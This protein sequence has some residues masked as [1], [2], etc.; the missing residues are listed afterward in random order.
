MADVRCGVVVV[1]RRDETYL[2]IRRAAHV[3][4]PGAWCFVGGAIEAGESE[5]AAVVREFQEEVGAT[6]R[7]LRRIWEYLRPDGSL[8]LAWWLADLDPPDAELWPNPA[9]VAELRWLRPAEI[10]CLPGLLD[11]NRDF[12]RRLPAL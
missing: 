8:R 1:V 5:A 6:V 2:V 4:A 3:P 10:E 9:E 7:P 12:L 11:S